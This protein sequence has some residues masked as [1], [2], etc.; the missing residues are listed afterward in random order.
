M[1][2]EYRVSTLAIGAAALILLLLIAGRWSGGVAQQRATLKTI[3]ADLYAVHN[4]I[5]STLDS[6]NAKLATAE[7]M[8]ASFEQRDDASSAELVNGLSALCHV[9]QTVGRLRSVASLA[10]AGQLNVIRN[11]SVRGRLLAL[12]SDLAEL[13]SHE[14]LVLERYR[15]RLEDSLSPGMWRYVFYGESGT[16]PID[17]RATLRELA[18]VRFEGTLRSAIR[19]LRERRDRLALSAKESEALLT[20]LHAPSG[21]VE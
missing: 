7:H 14:G 21:D 15:A 11:D 4:D 20:A 16:F 18:A 19:T 12:D 1:K 8:L 9:P 3:T 6:T 17:Y 2:R 5:T 10:A 13:R